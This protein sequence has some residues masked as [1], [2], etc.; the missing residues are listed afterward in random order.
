M[1]LGAL[2]DWGESVGLEL[3]NDEYCGTQVKYRWRCLRCGGV[4]E[5]HKGTIEQSM[6]R[7]F[8]SCKTCAGTNRTI[9]LSYVVECARSRGWTVDSGGYESATAL[10]QFRCRAGHAVALSWNSVQQGRGCTQRGCPDN[11]R[12]PV[13]QRA[14]A[15]AS[16]TSA[17]SSA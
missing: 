12:F 14:G 15:N 2:S 3:L 13:W 5:R 1:S 16:D 10:M 4:D 11:R 6:R 7:G 17:A 9:D 8:L